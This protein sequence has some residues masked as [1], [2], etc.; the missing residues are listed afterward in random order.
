MT[1]RE[2]EDCYAMPTAWNLKQDHGIPKMR[3]TMWF[4]RLQQRCVTVA[5]MMC[6]GLAAHTFTGHVLQ[7]GRLSNLGILGGLLRITRVISLLKLRASRADRSWLLPGFYRAALWWCAECIQPA[8][9]C[10][11][12]L[13]MEPVNISRVWPVLARTC[14][15][16][17][18]RTCCQFRNKMLSYFLF[19]ADGLQGQNV[20]W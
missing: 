13:L 17:F 9:F 7:A 6:P 16:S 19:S 18:W 20:W 15:K 5:R 11:T 10:D 1:E 12:V 8:L 3:W 4:W 2:Q 14:N